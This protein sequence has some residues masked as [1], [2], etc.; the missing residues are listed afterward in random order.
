MIDRLK[1]WGTLLLG[2]SLL[3]LQSCV[4]EDELDLPEE[5]NTSDFSE[6]VAIVS[7][8]RGIENGTIREGGC[9]QML[10]PLQLQ[11]N[12][13]ISIT[14]SDFEGLRELAV[15][16]T[17]SQHVNAIEFPFVVTKQD[18]V[19][20][21]ENEQ[22]FLDLLDDCEI[23]TLRD[24]FDHFYTQCFD[25]VYPVTMI[26][27]DSNEVVITDQSSYFAFE[28]QQGFDKQPSFKY[29]IEIF[30]YAADQNV[31]I[32]NAYELLA[33]FD[34]CVKCPRVF[35]TLDT[36][37]VNRFQFDAAFDR[38][39][40][41][42]YGWYIND[43]KVEIDGGEVQ[44][45]NKLIET[46][47]SGQFEICIKTSLP[48]G[49]CF[50][51]TEYCQTITVDACPFVSYETEELNSNTYRFTANFETKDL[52]EYYW[53]IYKNDDLIFSELEDAAGD[54]S[55]LYQF[56]V[57]TYEVCLEAEIDE[58]PEVLRYCTEIIVD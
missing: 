31:P 49:D 33:S 52:L 20:N 38:M 48:D 19:K 5:I 27:T 18:L 3:I 6:S 36:I 53:S 2:L 11:F 10:Y 44:G 25:L 50:T 47:P 54:D 45:D 1:V 24:E 16:N 37:S 41:I 28:L 42:S 39:S 29:P 12:N 26:N 55:L 35:F 30:N 14:V 46:F 21:I 4:S 40:D 56:E 51:G 15:G 58:C 32:E 57:G 17:A 23:L 22:E 34:S 13:E 7:L 8:M 43:E 9:F